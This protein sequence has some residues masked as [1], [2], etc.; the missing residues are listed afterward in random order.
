MN[1]LE[2]IF[3][4]F[5]QGITEFLPVSSSGHLAI[6]E[7]LFHIDTDTGVLFDVMLH[8]GTLAAIFLVYWRDIKKIFLAV[9]NIIIDII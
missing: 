4:G 1:L 8:V 6:F 7:N 9:I 3:L 5:I 2:S